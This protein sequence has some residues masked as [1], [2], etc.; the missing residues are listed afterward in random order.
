MSPTSLLNVAPDLLRAYAQGGR[1]VVPVA[2][3]AERG[4]ALAAC[5]VLALVSAALIATGG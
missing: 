4:W 1:P 5:A 2:T 3:M